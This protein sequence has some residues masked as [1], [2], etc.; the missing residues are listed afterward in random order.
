MKSKLNLMVMRIWHQLKSES[1][2]DLIEY[3]LL[4]G[5]IALG[6]ISAI[7]PIGGVLYSYYQYIHDQLHSANPSYF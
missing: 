4:V 5:F 2:Q 7:K 1:G 3:S 6:V